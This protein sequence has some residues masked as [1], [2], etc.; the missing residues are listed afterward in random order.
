MKHADLED[1]VFE[2]DVDGRKLVV[3]HEA[4]EGVLV[5]RPRREGQ[6]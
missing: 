3:G 5:E 2:L 4:L 1:D 6:A